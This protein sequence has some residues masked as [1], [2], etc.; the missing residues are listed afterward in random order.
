MD[1]LTVYLVGAALWGN[2]AFFRQKQKFPN[3]TLEKQIAVGLLNAA[4]WPI[5]L[6][7]VICKLVYGEEI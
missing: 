3:T 6:V 5:A 4:L 7:V 2:I 1:V